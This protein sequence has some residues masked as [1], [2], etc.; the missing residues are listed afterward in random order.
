M[1]QGSLIYLYVALYL[2]GGSSSLS[3]Q[4]CDFSLSGKVVDL[5]DGTPIFG[6]LVSVGG[7]TFFNQSDENG[8]FQIKGLCLGAFDLIVEHPECPTLKRQIQRQ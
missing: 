8:F 7:T 6:A 2:I 4:S 1:N 3:G 5:H